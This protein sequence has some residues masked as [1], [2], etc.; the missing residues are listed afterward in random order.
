MYGYYSYANIASSNND[1]ATVEYIDDMLATL[2]ESKSYSSLIIKNNAEIIEDLND[3]CIK[4]DC[5]LLLV[6]TPMQ[7]TALEHPTSWSKLRHEAARDFAKQ[8]NITFIDLNYDVDIGIDWAH[9]T[10]DHGIHMNLNGAQKVTE[11]IG[12]YLSKNYELLYYPNP[13]YDKHKELYDK[14]MAAS[15][16]ATA[17]E[18]KDYL[19]YIKKS[20]LNIVVIMSV[21]NG[22]RNGLSDNDMETLAE[23]GLK[24]DFKNMGDSSSFIAIFDGNKVL[25]E[26]ISD[27]SQT[28][29]MTIEDDSY[30]IASS[31][32][33]DGNRS[34]IV[35][36]QNDLS[37]NQR[38]INFVIYEKDS[39]MVIDKAYC[40][41]Y[42][43]EHDVVHE[44]AWEI[45]EYQQYLLGRK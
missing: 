36:N 34:S 40:D 14:Y 19:E 37:L 9:D 39:G 15:H 26:Q 17:Y 28:K 2:G 45:F 32:Y 24:S 7:I 27:S 18:L 13:D 21:K 30:Y 5:K 6:K 22:M 10:C 16:I 41:T 31:G 4:N 44:S 33:L 8:Y 42:V 35:I 12:D 3:I 11:Y 25:Y 38:G 20:N 23:F 43:N 1:R 29:Y